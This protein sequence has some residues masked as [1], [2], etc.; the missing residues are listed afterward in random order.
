MPSFPYP[1]TSLRAFTVVF[2]EAK[3]ENRPDQNRRARSLNREP[4]S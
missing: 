1:G 4:R 2:Y 3:R